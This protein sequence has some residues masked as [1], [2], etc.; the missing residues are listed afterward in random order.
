LETVISVRFDQI[1][2][3]GETDYK[4]RYWRVLPS[5]RSPVRD[6][7]RREEIGYRPNSH[8]EP[9]RVEVLKTLRVIVPVTF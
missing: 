5:S 1:L 6:Q 3:Q 2:R 9:P 8:K 4:I 7:D